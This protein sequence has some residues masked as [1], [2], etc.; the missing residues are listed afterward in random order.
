MRRKTARYRS[1]GRWTTGLVLGGLLTISANASAQ[2]EAVC[3]D[4]V[5]EA[6]EECDDGNRLAGD[7]CSVFCEIEPPTTFCRLAASACDIV[8]KCTG[9]DPS[10]PADTFHPR[11]T[12]CRASAGTCDPAEFCS[13]LSNQCPPDTKST[14][15]CRPSAGRCDRAEF[16]N[17]VS[18]QCPP[19]TK[20][21]M[22]CRPSAGECDPAEFCNGVSNQC[23]VDARSTA[24]CR[25]ADGP[26]DL[27]EFCDG[28][29]NDCPSDRFDAGT[30][31][32]TS[33]NSCDPAESCDGLGPAC[34]AN[35]REPDG[36]S[37]NDG[38]LC[39]TPDECQDGICTGNPNICGDGIT[40]SACGEECDDG[41][42]VDRDGCSPFCQGTCLAGDINGDG[43]VD[44]LDSVLLRR[45]RAGEA[46]VFCGDMLVQ[47]EIGEECEPDDDE[48][49]PGNCTPP[50]ESEPCRCRPCSHD[51]CITG[52]ALELCGPCVFAVCEVDP[53]CCDTIWDSRCVGEVLSVCGISC[54]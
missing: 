14:M 49:C 3:G 38:N 18:D 47:T 54:P 53:L 30:E 29:S 24:Q 48:A 7:C 42:N 1:V 2:E 37:C 28:V 33:T 9:T 44:I 20:S 32:R 8:E 27:S 23:P 17:G 50:G 40:Q 26:C 36:T 4:G 35:A 22:Q 12:E 45:I 15:Q 52:T 31:C 41:N 16:C 10:C 13:G 46:L 6:P 19:D 25:A 43:L 11:T 21:T 5:L 34:P 51:K 39:T